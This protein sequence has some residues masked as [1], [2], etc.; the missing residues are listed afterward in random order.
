[1]FGK[2][3]TAFGD[4]GVNIQENNSRRLDGLAQTIYT[5]QEKPTPEM[6]EKLLEI[7]G[8]RRVVY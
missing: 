1:M 4:M 2:F 5:I 8:V 6:Q 3:G 7:D